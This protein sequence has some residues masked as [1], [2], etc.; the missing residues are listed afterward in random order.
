MQC[1]HRT[2]REVALFDSEIERTLRRQRR[3][4][5]QQD[6]QEVWQPIEEILIELP[7]EEEMTENEANRRALRDFALPG[8]QGSQTSIARPTG[9][10]RT[11]ILIPNLI[12]NFTLGSGN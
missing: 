7:F 4:T 12:S 9:L 8:T 3:H 6:E 1:M 11:Q 10:A 5:P 2:S